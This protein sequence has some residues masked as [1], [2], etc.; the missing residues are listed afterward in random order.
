MGFA[1]EIF[2]NMKNKDV[3]SWTT[4][5]LGYINR[6]QVDIARQYFAQ[7]PERDYVLW[8]AMIDGYLRVNR[9]REAL[10]LFREM[11]TSNIRRD[12]F[13]IVRILTACANLGALELG[14]WIKTYTDKNKV[15]NDIFVGNALIDM[16]CKCGDVEKAQRVF[17]K[18]LRKDKFTW[19]AMIVGLAISGHGD[20]ALDM[21]SQ[22]LRASIRPDEVTY[23]GVLSACTHNGNENFVINSCN[24]R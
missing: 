20:K 21:F 3:I 6:R 12:E 10:T 2:G 22:M 24:L 13:T 17:R 11:Q 8:T 15:K 14:E 4:I 18:M 16:Y 19:T 1:L 23:V 9:Y 7:M 5:V